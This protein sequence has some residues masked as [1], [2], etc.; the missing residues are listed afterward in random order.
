MGYFMKMDGV[1][2]DWKIYILKKLFFE[3]MSMVHKKLSS[4]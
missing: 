2:H 1:V 3:I 4:Y